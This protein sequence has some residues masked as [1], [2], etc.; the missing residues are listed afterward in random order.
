MLSHELRT[1]LTPI[2][3][4]ARI[5]KVERDPVEVH[6]AAQVIERNALLQLRLVDDLLELNHTTRGT[7]VLDSEGAVP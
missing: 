4:W 7:A 5:L 2:L 3:G 1:P 6:C